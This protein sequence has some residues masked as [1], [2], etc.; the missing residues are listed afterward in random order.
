MSMTVDELIERLE[1][2]RE[3]L[4]G[5]TYVMAQHQPSYPLREKVGHVWSPSEDGDSEWRQELQA[6]SVCGCQVTHPDGEPVQVFYNPE[7]A[8]YDIC[9]ECFLKEDGH[10]H[11]GQPV[12]YVV[13]TG[14]PHDMNPYGQSDAWNN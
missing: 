7:T 2:I 14:A 10:T 5:D 13:L 6:C 3:S 8:K 1:G 12:V 11:D 4:G 9:G